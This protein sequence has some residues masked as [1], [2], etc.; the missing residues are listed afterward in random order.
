[1]IG[2]P[3]YAAAWALAEA[4][5]RVAEL[6]AIRLC[7][8]DLKSSRVSAGGSSNT[9]RRWVELTGWGSEQLDKF[10]SEKPKPITGHPLLVPGK[11][12]RSIL[13]ELIAS[14]LRRAGLANQAGVRP[15]SIPAWRGAKEL[16]EGASIDEVALLLGM[17]SLDRAAAFIGFD[18]RTER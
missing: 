5:A 13:H 6:G 9:E 3:R 2:D 7:D 1:M 14:T 4:T 18:W 8:V 15:N 12:S 11:G 16:A 17:R 10:L